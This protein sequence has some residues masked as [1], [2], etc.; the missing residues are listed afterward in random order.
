MKWEKQ[1]NTSETQRPSKAGNSSAAKTKKTSSKKNSFK[2]GL[3]N[4]DLMSN[5]NSNI[6]IA[7]GMLATLSLGHKSDWT[8][9]LAK[10]DPEHLRILLQEVM[11]EIWSAEETLTNLNQNLSKRFAGICLL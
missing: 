5:L 6:S 7:K 1:T 3:S 8:N 4:K 2:I 9:K 10:T 11:E